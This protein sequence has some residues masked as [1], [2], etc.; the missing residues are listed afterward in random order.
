MDRVLNAFLIALKE[1]VLTDNKWHIEYIYRVV[2]SLKLISLKI[3]ISV[4]RLLLF[5][6]SNCLEKNALIQPDGNL[7]FSTDM[8]DSG[9]I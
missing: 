2:G 5:I 9:L 4:V 6:L 3:K 7:I 8:V 1:E